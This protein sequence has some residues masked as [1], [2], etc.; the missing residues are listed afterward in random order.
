MDNRTDMRNGHPDN[1]WLRNGLIFS[2]T[3]NVLYLYTHFLAFDNGEYLNFFYNPNWYWDRIPK[4]DVP[5]RVIHHLE[6]ECLV[7][8]NY[9]PEQR[10][11]EFEQ[12]P[13]CPP[14]HPETPNIGNLYVMRSTYVESKDGF[15]KFT[16]YEDFRMQHVRSINEFD[17]DMLLICTVLT[18]TPDT[19]KSIYSLDCFK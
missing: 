12:W 2:S 7:L 15:L 6:K 10:G 14:F 18:K 16:D 4:K 5:Q 13:D 11:H 3:N 19:I 8:R 9:D 1:H 17:V